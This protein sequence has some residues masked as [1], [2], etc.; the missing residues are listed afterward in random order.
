MSS[1]P[2]KSGPEPTTEEIDLLRL[3]Q[4]RVADLRGCGI[5]QQGQVTLS[6]TFPLGGN[7]DAEKVPFE[8]F[9]RDQ[10]GA[11]MQTL[12]QFMLNDDAVCLYRIC[13]I[14][15]QK[16]NRQEL[17]DWSAYA[18]SIWKQTLDATPLGFTVGDKLYTVKDAV[19]LMLYGFL[20]HTK[21]EPAQEWDRL[22]QGG[23][24]TIYFIVQR[25]LFGL[26]YCLNL[27]DS[28]ILYWLDQPEAPIP[29]LGDVQQQEPQPGGTC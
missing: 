15:W 26:F 23:K 24:A 4:K 17:K 9:N 2:S 11:A 19:D 6:V 20:A 8:G 1:T 5:V 3:F 16:C 29:C 10:F 25:S 13:N 14:I 21:V 12:R 7:E 18:R 22:S 28:V 27:L